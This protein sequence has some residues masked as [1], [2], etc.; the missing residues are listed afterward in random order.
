MKLSDI[1]LQEVRFYTYTAMVK[2]I[3]KEGTPTVLAQ[4]IRALPGVT[5][6]TMVRQD[7][8]GQGHIF[9]VKLISQKG[10]SEA[11]ESLK[12]NA[13]TKYSEINVFN[14]AEKTIE[15]KS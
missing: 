7:L 11:F 14:V 8:D 1:I 6:V 10:G 5:T 13:I 4:L 12:K 2:V 9:K 15:R 3:S